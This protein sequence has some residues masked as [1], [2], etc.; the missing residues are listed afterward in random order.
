MTALGATGLPLLVIDHPLGGER[1]DGVAR[2]APRPSSSSPACSPAQPHAPPAEVARVGA[3]T[4]S[5]GHPRPSRPRGP[6]TISRYTI[7]R[8]TPDL[9][10][11]DDPDVSP[12]S[13]RGVVR[14]AALRRA[15]PRA[16]G[17]DARRAAT[18]RASLGLMPPLWRE[19]TLEKLAVNA[20]MAGCEPAAFP[21]VVAAVRGD[22]RSGVQ[23]LRRAGHHASGGAAARRQR[24]L[25]PPHRAARRQRLLRARVP[26]QRHD[27]A[28]HPPDPAERGRRL[29]GPLRHG[30]AGQPGE[31]RLLHRRGR[32]G[33]GPCGARS[34]RATW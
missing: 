26:R 4:S 18:A 1:P 9:T 16:R 14:R 15:H 25:R 34:A 2:R 11:D 17:R 21:I 28:R 20:V 8:L 5:N 6:A 24:S 33:R 19:A 13:R 10:L 7:R 3:T 22:A 12:S 23:P 31:V 32:G 30:D 27:R 29:A